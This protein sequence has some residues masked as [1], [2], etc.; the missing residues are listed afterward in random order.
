MTLEHKSIK[1]IRRKKVGGVVETRSSRT[2]VFRW[3]VR[4]PSIRVQ[5]EVLSRHTSSCPILTLMLISTSLRLSLLSISVYG[6]TRDPHRQGCVNDKFWLQRKMGRGYEEKFHRKIGIYDQALNYMER[7]L[8]SI[9]I[10]EIQIKTR[11]YHFPPDWWNHP[12]FRSLATYVFVAYLWGD[13]DSDVADSNSGLYNSYW[14]ECG[15]SSQAKLCRHE[16][17][18]LAI[19]IVGTD[20]KNPL[21]KILKRIRIQISIAAYL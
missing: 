9:T 20:P 11:R 3:G 15:L 4:N 13:R 7:C 17:F 10:R 14:L 6:S 12:K 19:P 1:V 5:W 18:D 8:T 16:R 21:P 2:Y